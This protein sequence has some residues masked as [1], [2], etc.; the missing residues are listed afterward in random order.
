MLLRIYLKICYAG[1]SVVSCPHNY[2]IK[3]ATTAV[4]M[5]ELSNL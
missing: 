1:E 2:A 3:T 5:H 4:S